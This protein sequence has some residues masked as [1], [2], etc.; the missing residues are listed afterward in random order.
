[1]TQAGRQAGNDGLQQTRWTLRSL[2]IKNL[3]PGSSESEPHHRSLCP[4]KRRVT[5]KLRRTVSQVPVYQI[6]SFS[7]SYGLWDF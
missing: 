2:E 4:K 3:L 5:L 1:M 7:P 6:K